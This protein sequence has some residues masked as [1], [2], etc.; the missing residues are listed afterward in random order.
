MYVMNTTA[1]GVMVTGSL[2]QKQG[3]VMKLKVK[4]SIY[5]EDDLLNYL[6]DIA[7]YNERSL[8]QMIT[9]ILNSYKTEDE[10]NK[11]IY[12]ED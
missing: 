3:E 1:G 11:L 8:N 7:N 6:K 9:I 10:E 2:L 12:M 4:T 5:L